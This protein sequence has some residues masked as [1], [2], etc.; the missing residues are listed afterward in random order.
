M[1]CEL[2]VDPL[3]CP[4]ERCNPALDACVPDAPDAAFGTCQQLGAD[5]ADEII[6]P[7]ETALSGCQGD[8]S[9]P[10]GHWCRPVKKD[11]AVCDSTA[12]CVPF[13]LE[14]ELCEEAQDLLCYDERCDP[15]SHF[16][17]AAGATSVSKVA[18]ALQGICLALGA[19]GTPPV[20][21]PIDVPV[22]VPVDAPVEAPIEVP[23]TPPQAPTFGSSGGDKK[24]GTGGTDASAPLP[25]PA[26]EPA[27]EPEPE[28]EP[29]PAPEPAKKYEC[30]LDTDCGNPS[31][32]WCRAAV[33]SLTGSCLPEPGKVPDIGG[34]CATHKKKVGKPC[35]LP[36]AVAPC[37]VTKCIDGLVCL[38]T[39][40][41]GIP[42]FGSCQPL[43][44]VT[45][46]P[47]FTG[48]GT[49]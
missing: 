43:G 8:E 22:D 2:E 14:G 26:P 4:R 10:S 25:E 44:A 11:H 18:S 35:T 21:V 42:G 6:E 16:C 31:L 19:V 40:F 30:F 13:A 24:G 34:K 49:P 9:C 38:P 47:G 46:A 45:R 39:Q 36:G 37:K 5:T 27:P 17:Y 15:A 32:T 48:Q 29:A 7:D 33:D 20:D 41:P 28:P 12:E 3:L 1:Q 23:M